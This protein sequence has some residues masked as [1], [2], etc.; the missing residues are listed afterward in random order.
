MK[1]T[2]TMALWLG[3]TLVLALGGAE[4]WSQSLED[5]TIGGPGLGQQA[6]AVAQ[7]V[8]ER[9]ETQARQEAGGLTWLTSLGKRYGVEILQAPD[10]CGCE[11]SVFKERAPI[12]TLKLPKAP[13]SSREAAALSYELRGLIVRRG[14]HRTPVEIED[15]AAFDALRSRHG[16]VLDLE[17]GRLHYSASDPAQY[18]WFWDGEVAH[19]RISAQADD[20]L[21]VR[22]RRHDGKVD[23]YA[24]AGG[25]L[26]RLEG[27][28]K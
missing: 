22:L 11:F 12:G 25:V 24:I 27:E 14:L 3:A 4:A 20:S 21:T 7:A 5:P 8:G 2:E 18:L 28:G 15:Q 13:T 19:A 1:R 6:R 26:S 10:P 9:R 17:S 16:M 23:H